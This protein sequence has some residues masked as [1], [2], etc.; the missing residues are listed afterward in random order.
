[1]YPYRTSLCQS[2]ISKE[3]KW[4]LVV[5]WKWLLWN[6][7]QNIYNHNLRSNAHQKNHGKLT[8]M[9]PFY[10]TNSLKANN[11]L[12][13][14]HNGLWYASRPWP[15]GYYSCRKSGD[16]TEMS[17]KVVSK[18]FQTRPSA[19]GMSDQ[20]MDLVI[21]NFCPRRKNGKKRR[22]MEIGKPR[23]ISGGRKIMSNCRIFWYWD[24]GNM[25]E[26]CHV[27]GSLW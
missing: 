1:M 26:I 13:L 23:F 21:K 8:L 24:K 17:K 11:G 22:K 15:Q 7:F 5:G 20:F 14:N 10:W 16:V 27:S 18:C 9:V 2:S 4:S 12:S 19:L 6:P 25:R 3:K